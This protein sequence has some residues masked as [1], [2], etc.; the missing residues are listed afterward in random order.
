M[1]MY[2]YDQ[3]LTDVRHVYEQLTGLPA[4]KIDLKN[5]RFPL[6]R[7]GDPANLVQREIDYLNLYL[8]NSGIS[9]RLSK[10]PTWAPPT[11]VCETADRYII[12]IELAGVSSQDVSVQILNHVLIVRGSR[13]FRRVSEDAQYY[14]SERVYGSFERLFGIPEH[15]KADSLRTSFTD[16][17]L[18]ITFSKV[19]EASPAGAQIKK[20]GSSKAGHESGDEKAEK[21]K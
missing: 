18:E 5:P 7:D 9:T 3:V 20:S 4:P 12:S 13:R 15:V 2:S 6:P 11:E 1:A 8:V 17:V 16:G 14:S 19:N 10:M 21:Q